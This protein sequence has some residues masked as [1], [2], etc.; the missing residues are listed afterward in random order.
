VIDVVNHHAR[1]THQ[2]EVHQQ[3]GIAD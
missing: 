2:S 3:G 1:Q